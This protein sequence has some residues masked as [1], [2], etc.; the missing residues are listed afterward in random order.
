MITRSSLIAS[1]LLAAPVLT[2]AQTA[3]QIAAPATQ[4]A[5]A[6]VPAVQYQSVFQAD[7]KGVE[8]GNIDWIRANAEVAQFP[9]GHMDVLNWEASQPKGAMGAPG[10]S[11]PPKK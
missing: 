7:A 2:A 11:M 10:H 9:R 4:D 6:K 5:A 8:M 1:L 3:S